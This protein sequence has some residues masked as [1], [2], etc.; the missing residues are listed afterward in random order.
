MVLDVGKENVCS[1][2]KKGSLFDIMHKKSFVE[3]PGSQCCKCW[4]PHAVEYC[5]TKIIFCIL[6]DIV[7]NFTRLYGAALVFEWILYQWGL[8]EWYSGIDGRS[9]DC[10]K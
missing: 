5:S 10:G 9:V 4:K 2:C 7:Y 3:G 1:V 8:G 6:C